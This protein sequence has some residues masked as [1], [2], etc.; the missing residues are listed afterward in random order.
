MTQSRNERNQVCTLSLPGGK[1]DL[2]NASPLTTVTCFHC[3]AAL[4]RQ[5]LCLCFQLWQHLASGRRSYT[6]VNK[7]IAHLTNE[8]LVPL[9]FGCIFSIIPFLYTV[10]S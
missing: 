8:D 1:A 2:L 7:G 5:R 6:W 4:F 10:D 3:L 9:A